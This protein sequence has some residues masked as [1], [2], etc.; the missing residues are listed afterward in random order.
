M[1]S[2]NSTYKWMFLYIPIFAVLYCAIVVFSV[3]VIVNFL[4]LPTL[5]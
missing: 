1:M 3:W 4:F 2:K 5:L